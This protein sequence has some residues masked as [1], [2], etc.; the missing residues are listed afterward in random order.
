MI[1]PGFPKQIPYLLDSNEKYGVCET[2]RSH[3][4][5][6]N[7][8]QTVIARLRAFRMLIF[9]CT[10]REQAQSSVQLRNIDL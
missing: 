3:C 2:A 4:P 9:V 5:S 7:S 6:E 8:N 1:I 10:G